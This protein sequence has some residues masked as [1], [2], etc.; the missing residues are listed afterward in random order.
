MPELCI[1]AF[2]GRCE[3]SGMRHVCAL[4]AGHK[5]QH[6]CKECLVTSEV[7]RLVSKGSIDVPFTSQCYQFW[8]YCRVSRGRHK[9]TEQV[10]HLDAHRCF[11]CGLQ[12]VRGTGEA[13]AA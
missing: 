9:C 5:D 4:L 8:G 7:R 1:K 2:M 6:V 13:G 11:H 3:P 10:G 12:L